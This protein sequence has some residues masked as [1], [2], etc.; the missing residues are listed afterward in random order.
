V[1]GLVG[2]DGELAVLD[3]LAARTAAGA[4]GVVLVSGEPGAGKTR[5]AREAAERARSAIVSWGA[6]RECEGA[7]GTMRPALPQPRSGCIASGEL[8]GSATRSPI[9]ASRPRRLHSAG[10]SWRC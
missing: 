3:S 2:R 8:A 7:G 10:V 9:S 4:G 6:C 1:G 5:L